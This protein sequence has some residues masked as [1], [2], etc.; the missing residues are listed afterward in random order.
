MNITKNIIAD[1]FPLYVEKECSPDTRALLEEYF[2]R[3]PQDAEELQ[4]I[5]NTSLPTG[6]PPPVK[7]LDE[8]RSLRE[9]RRIVRRGS[10][11]LG[12]AIF[13]SLAPFSILHTG[14]RTY[15]LLRESP[16]LALVYGLL[17]LG[18]WILWMLMR[19]RS[20]SL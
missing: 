16:G 14:E 10:W 4:R 9:A 20:R 8:A 15:W 3:H 1:L 11:L 2:Q 18:C 6:G 19:N 13:F 7:G 17:A 12:L 5:A